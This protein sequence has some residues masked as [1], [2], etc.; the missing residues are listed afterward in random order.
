MTLP[1]CENKN[2]D[3]FDTWA[4][5]PKGPVALVL[6]QKMQ[7]VE[8]PG[9]IVFPPTYAD[10]DYNI[11]ET[12]EGVKSATIDSVGSQANRIEPIF[13]AGPDTSD[14]RIPELVP[15]IDI[16]YPIKGSDELRTLSI[17]EVG[18]RLGD[19]II[20]STGLAEEAHKAFDRLNVRGDAEAIARL[21]PT[22]LVFGVWDSRDTQAKLP[23]LLQSVIR[24]EDI[25]CL[26]RSA[27]YNPAIDY[28]AADAFSDKEKEKAEGSTKN[29]LA[30]KGYVH[31]P[32]VR[33]H[34]GVIPR[35]D[36]L[37]TV[38]VNLVALRRLRGSDD[39]NKTDIL[40]RYILGIALVAAT[41]ELDG[42][43]RAGC[44]LVPDT[45]APAE[46]QSV[47]RNGMRTPVVL[48]HDRALDYAETAA[49]TFNVASPRKV[50][51]D[52]ERTKKDLKKG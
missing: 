22:S 28:S 46:W 45:D 3:T 5:D 15:Q 21:A 41:A 8:G 52:K 29:P 18:H 50:S 23:R 26:T 24:A 14:P 27:Q 20:R 11:D 25:A 12:P 39:G 33:T 42:F 16:A 37:R 17:F 4:T 36:I 43:L 13:R 10:I 35:G 19:A 1:T 7:P 9:G 2:F 6:R 51:F 31:V 47:E 32:A 49:D 44:L 34:G 30:Q 38:T 48:D 40:R